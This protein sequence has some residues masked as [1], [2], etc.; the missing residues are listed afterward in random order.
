MELSRD[1][2]IALFQ[3]LWWT[4]REPW[5][6]KVEATMLDEAVIDGNTNA[7]NTLEDRLGHEDLEG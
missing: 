7:T 1:V 6:L 3:P 5:I 2:T 4:H